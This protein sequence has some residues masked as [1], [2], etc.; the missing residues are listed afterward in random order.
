MGRWQSLS[1]PE[2]ERCMQ[3]ILAFEQQHQPDKDLEA[4]YNPRKQTPVLPNNL[5][6]TYTLN[7]R[8][9]I[10]KIIIKSTQYT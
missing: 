6:A 7:N 5:P 8:S 9:F 3:L 4:D 1:A 10:L 2:Q